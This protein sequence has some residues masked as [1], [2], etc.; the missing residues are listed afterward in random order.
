MRLLGS[1]A[2]FFI[3]LT[4]LQIIYF[5][6]V[7]RTRELRHSLHTQALTWIKVLIDFLLFY[8]LFILRRQRDKKRRII[9]CTL[10]NANLDQIYVL[11]LTILPVIYLMG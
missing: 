7:M 5:M 6:G 10:K 4:V 1:T 3:I 9:L 2:C 11:F 8:L